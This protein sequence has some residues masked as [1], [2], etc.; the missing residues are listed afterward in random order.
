MSDVAWT[1]VATPDGVAL[2][3][4]RRGEAGYAVDTTRTVASW[5]DGRATAT[6]S[7]AAAGVTP[8]DAWEIIE[9]SMVA[10]RAAGLRWGPR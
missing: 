7:N 4:V 3:V 8:E 1:V 5:A 2:A 9:S 6:A 10:S